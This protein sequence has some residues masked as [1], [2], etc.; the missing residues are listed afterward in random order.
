MVFAFNGK[1]VKI[2]KYRRCI[3]KKNGYN[4]KKER[5]LY[6][7]AKIKYNSTCI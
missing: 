2:E 6:F 3:I 5:M 4:P 1:E 7:Y